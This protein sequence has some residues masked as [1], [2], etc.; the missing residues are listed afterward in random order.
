MNRDKILAI[1]N[2]RIENKNIVKHMLAV[3]AFMRAL[4]KELNGDE[5]KWARAGLIHDLDYTDDV[6]P[7][8]HGL[9]M[10]E[11]LIEE[12][13]KM[14]DDILQAVAAHNWSNNGVKPVTKMD[15]AL[16]CGDSLTGLIVASTLVLPDRKLAS[17][18]TESVLNKFPRK[19]FAAGTRREEIKMCQEKLGIPLEKFVRICLKSMQGISDK[20]GL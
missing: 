11:I 18:T 1:I 2:K 7:A 14:A 13:V 20:L 3:E 8:E 5:E 6:K 9:K 10:K 19:D 16:F 12:N 15:W 17:L 4:A